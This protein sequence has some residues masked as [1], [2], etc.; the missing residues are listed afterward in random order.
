MIYINLNIEV[1]KSIHNNCYDDIFQTIAESRNIEFEIMYAKSWGLRFDSESKILNSNRGDKEKLL[2]E[3]QGLKIERFPVKDTKDYSEIIR[4]EIEEEKV[5]AIIGDAFY[6]HWVSDVYEKYH[7]DHV[8]LIIGYEDDKYIVTDAQ[9]AKPYTLLD[10]EKMEKCIRTLMRFNFEKPQKQIDFEHIIE[11]AFLKND[12]N[13]TLLEDLSKFIDYVARDFDIDE[14]IRRNN[15]FLEQS[16]IFTEI[17]NLGMGRYQFSEF[18]R[19]YYRKSGNERILY[20]SEHFKFLG[21]EWKAITGLMLKYRYVKENKKE[22]I[23]LLIQNKFKTIQLCEEEVFNLFKGNKEIA[24]KNVFSAESIANELKED[25]DIQ[26]L[27]NSKAFVIENEYNSACF[28]EPNR[29]FISD[30]TNIN[31]DVLK[32]NNS[33]LDLSGINDNLTCESQIIDIPKDSEGIILIGASEY[34]KFTDYI[35]LIDVNG[36]TIDR[37]IAFQTWLA[38]SMESDDTVVWSGEI[39]TISKMDIVKFP[40]QGNL[41]SQTINFNAFPV[42]KIVLPYN[43]NIHI[44]AISTFYS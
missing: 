7:T 39:G 32:N 41:Y 31:L 36:T 6:L 23:K 35:K 33:Y 38:Q 21:S 11:S 2:Y 10:S 17:D 27:F 20:L 8:F 25:L 14:E 4:K 43:P 34:N 9:F 24:I 37:K 15:G 42:E 13:N 40:I 3:Y 19:Y 12:F 26:H 28:S 1:K 29:F 30:T 16:L 5:V 18:L 44:F 22:R